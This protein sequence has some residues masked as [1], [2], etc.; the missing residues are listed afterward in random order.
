MRVTEKLQSTFDKNRENDKSNLEKL[1]ALGIDSKFA[2]QLMNM[3][4]EIWA[5]TKEILDQTDNILSQQAEILQLEKERHR[6]QR[7]TLV[8]ITK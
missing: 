8:N 2:K 5:T 1:L 6:L 3:F 4:E 7:T